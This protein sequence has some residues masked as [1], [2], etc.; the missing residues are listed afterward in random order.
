MSLFH[1]RKWNFADDSKNKKFDYQPQKSNPIYSQENITT[2]PTDLQNPSVRPH[3]ARFIIL[4]TS[5]VLYMRHLHKL[6]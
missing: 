4:I 3:I 2:N 1:T 5:L 6:N